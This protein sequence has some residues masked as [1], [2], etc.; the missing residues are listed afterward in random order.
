MSHPLNKKVNFGINKSKNVN[1]TNITYY[2]KLIRLISN[3]VKI[4]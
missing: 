2:K 3:I 1:N 4:K